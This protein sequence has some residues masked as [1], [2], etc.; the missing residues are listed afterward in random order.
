VD[1]D[2]LNEKNDGLHHS[3]EGRLTLG[4]RF[5]EKAVAPI[6]DNAKKK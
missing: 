2:D 6:K 1:T 4:K 3:K 5:A